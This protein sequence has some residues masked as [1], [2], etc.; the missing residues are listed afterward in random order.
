MNTGTPSET[1]APPARVGDHSARRFSRDGYLVL[2]NLATGS[3]LEFF[4]EYTV[5]AAKLDVLQQDDPDVPG[6][7]CR[8]GDPMTDALLETLLPQLEEVTGKRL[9]PAYS[10]FRVHKCGDASLTRCL[11]KLVFRDLRL[12]VAPEFLE[13]GP[14]LVIRCEDRDR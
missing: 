3:A 7:P 14:K 10:C 1:S 8:Y 2:R 6:T 12:F 13:P 5:K 4:H 11:A 9:H